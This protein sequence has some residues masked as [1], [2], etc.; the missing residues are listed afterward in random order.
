MLYRAFHQTGAGQERIVRVA[1]PLTDI[2]ALIEFF[3]QARFLLGL[4]VA[5]AAGLV[6]AWVFSRH[7][8]RRFQ[9]LVQFSGEVAGGS[10]PQNFFLT[11]G[12]DEIALARTTPE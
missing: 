9:R 8:S 12:K 1:V 3:S 10:F 11:H 2:E 4:A 5:A 6:L 7:L